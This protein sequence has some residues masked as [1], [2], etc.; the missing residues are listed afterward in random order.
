M[1]KE[2]VKSLTEAPAPMP[3][4]QFLDIPSP[5][6]SGSKPIGII[7][8]SPI[9]GKEGTYLWFGNFHGRSPT[10]EDHRDMI[11]RF[12]TRL[13]ISNRAEF[14]VG[15]AI[16][17]KQCDESTGKISTLSRWR[18][19]SV[20]GYYV[21]AP[22]RAMFN[23]RFSIDSEEELRTRLLKSGE[24]EYFD[25]LFKKFKTSLPDFK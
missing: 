10:D 24:P 14:V 3:K 22:K 6:E 4:P 2:N 5:F 15:P 8:K 25:I 19:S 23:M 18:Y 1:G 13:M 9:D 21:E 12:L 7:T 16:N 17:V 11:G 20:Y